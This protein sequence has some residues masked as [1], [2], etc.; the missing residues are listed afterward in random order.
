MNQKI[1]QI[2]NNPSAPSDG[3]DSEPSFMAS[4]LQESIIPNFKVSQLESYDG[5]TD[6]TDDVNSFQVVMLL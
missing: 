5:T 1:Q 2:C 6:P 3:F 4:I